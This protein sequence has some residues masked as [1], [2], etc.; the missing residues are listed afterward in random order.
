ME[1]SGNSAG[2]VWGCAVGDSLGLPYENL[3]PERV[4]KLLGRR[5]LRHRFVFRYGMISDDTEHTLIIARCCH[6]NPGDP[7][8]FEKM[9]S[10]ELRRWLAGFPPGIGLATLRSLLKLCIG[11]PPAR[12]GV[13]SAGNG[14]AMRSA[15]IGSLIPDNAELRRQYIE[16]STGITHTDPKAFL[17]SRA[18][19][20][21]AAKLSNGEWQTKPPIDAL[22]DT[23]NLISNDP[24]WREI[25]SQIAEN[26]REGKN[27]EKNSGISGYVYETVPFAITCWY[28]N[29]G[30]FE[31]TVMRSIRGGG[32]TDSTSAICGALAGITGPIPAHFRENLLLW[33]VKETDLDL[34]T[35]HRPGL[36]KMWARNFIF[37]IVILAHC[38]RRCCPPY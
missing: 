1:I 23:L 3:A 4:G 30:N 31:Q 26:L 21:I 12:S 10:R 19:A 6:Q 34:K 37:F 18:V 8:A 27:I 7:D 35:F 2:C 5:R 32:D 9:L 15:I 22:M 14:P 20:E 13:F 11:I 38:L 24:D 16:R 33:P 29:F 25:T 17:G 28:Q 36:L